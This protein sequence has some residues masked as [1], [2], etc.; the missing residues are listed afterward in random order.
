MST[1]IPHYE[2]SARLLGDKP[3][4]DSGEALGRMRRAQAEMRTSI[5]N[6][7]WKDTR[8]CESFTNLFIEEIRNARLFVD[9]GAEFGFYSYLALTHM[10]EN[11]RIICIE[12]DP[13]RSELLQEFFAGDS[14]VQVVNLAAHC[15][16]SMLTLTKPAGCSA[17][18]A[19]VEGAKFVVRA[20]TLDNI[21]GDSDVDV[22][23]MDIEGA[24]ANAF[25]GLHKTLQ[26]GR[27][28]IFLE[29]HSWIDHIRPGG[30][31]EMEGLLKSSGYTIEN[32][33]RLPPRTVAELAGGRFLL[34]PPRSVLPASFRDSL[35]SII[36]P[37][38]N[39]DRF[40]ERAL[41]SVLRQDHADLEVIV[42]DS[43]SSDATSE[44]V[45]RYPE[46]QLIQAPG[47]GYAESVNRG[48][49]TAKGGV[50]GIQHCDDYYAPGAARQAVEIL[51]RYPQA[52]LV[53]GKRVVVAA[54][55]EEAG[56][57]T[58]AASRWID[59]WDLIEGAATPCH[60][61]TFIR[62]S[63]IEDVGPLNPEVEYSAM[64]D[65]CLRLL[66]RWPGLWV[67]RFWGFRQMQPRSR[68]H[69][70]CEEI[71]ADI[72]RS[73]ELW[74]DSLHPES[75]AEF[76]DRIG[77][78]AH[79]R[80]AHFYNLAGSRSK[81]RGLLEQAIAIYPGLLASEPCRRLVEDLELSTS[82]VRQTRPGHDQLVTATRP[83]DTIE[84]DSK[85]AEDPQLT[86]Y[87][88]P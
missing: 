80:Q 9:V 67:D 51:S 71:A 87:A 77:A 28:H 21:I 54:N 40:I 34:T 58:D 83:V 31:V 44:I 81:A 68:R 7:T 11:G 4:L 37:V 85:Q 41:I 52:G 17:T 78:C 12:A 24:E 82:S 42:V 64:L 5:D 16:T 86:W 36:I 27:V 23:K 30:K 39:G 60:E 59:F 73:F 61:S 48:L 88:R 50:V 55:G 46:A 26:S 20:D 65:L 15:S 76:G 47:K 10:P 6:G 38:L 75:R 22:I 1:Q 19:N 25:Q 33:D 2:E 69:T 3:P 13:I 56:R 14:R 66:S 32:V 72:G 49:E 18:S 29:M 53:A 8:W 70:A 79:F 62:R 57:S 63:L 43:G 84:L 45:G 35:V 74:V